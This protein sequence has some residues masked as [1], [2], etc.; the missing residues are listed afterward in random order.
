MSHM[1]GL[2]GSNCKP[3]LNWNLISGVFAIPEH[4]YDITANSKPSPLDR[5]QPAFRDYIDYIVNNDIAANEYFSSQD[6]VNNGALNRG[7]CHASF[8]C[9]NR[10]LPVIWAVC[11]PHQHVSAHQ[12][13]PTNN[14]AALSHCYKMTLQHILQKSWGYLNEDSSYYI[15]TAFFYSLIHAFWTVC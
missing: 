3:F 8:G 12:S 6:K 7:W 2:V 5:T 9:C 14:I 10:R 15:H 4:T 13:L 11:W 1:Q